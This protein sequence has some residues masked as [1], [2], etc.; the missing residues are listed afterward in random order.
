MTVDV[1]QDPG[2]EGWLAWVDSDTG[3]PSGALQQPLVGGG[4]G[5]TLDRQAMVRLVKDLQAEHGGIRIWVI[6]LQQ[7]ARGVGRNNSASLGIQMAGYGMWLG[8]LAALEVPVVELTSQAWRKALGVTQ[9]RYPKEA[10]L[11]KKATKAEQK[12]WNTRD[13][14]RQDK[15][16]KEGLQKAIQKAQGLY[17]SVDMRRN[18]R[19]KVPSP[20][21]CIAHL[22]ARLGT[23]LHGGG[24]ALG[25][26]KELPAKRAARAKRKKKRTVRRRKKAAKAKKAAAPHEVAATGDLFA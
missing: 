23:Q 4:K 20:D 9:P 16:R 14:K 5:D 12:A 26:P 7:P 8:I 18:G 10:A 1:G 3:R 15:Q 19:C 17:P 2:K 13:R 6:E 11:P 22:L 25:A 24:G 21:K